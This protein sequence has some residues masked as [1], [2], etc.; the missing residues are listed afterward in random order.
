MVG[1]PSPPIILGANLALEMLHRSGTD[2][3]AVY[4]IGKLARKPASMRGTCA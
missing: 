1:Y 3:V 4:G 2:R